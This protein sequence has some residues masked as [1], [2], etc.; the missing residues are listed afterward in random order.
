[1]VG[2]IS[3]KIPKIPGVRNVE[4]CNI[5]TQ[6]PYQVVMTHLANEHN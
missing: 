2:Y 3:T 6:S 4:A 1:M 5:F